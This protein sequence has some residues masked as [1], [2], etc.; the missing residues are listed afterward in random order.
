MNDWMK[1]GE[2]LYFRHFLITGLMVGAVMFLPNNALAQ[3][4]DSNGQQMIQKASEQANAS[5][6]AHITG[7]EKGQ[8][9][10][11]PEQAIKNQGGVNINTPPQ[12]ASKKPTAALQNSVDQAKG[13][14]LSAIRKAEQVVKAPGLEKATTLQ[15]KAVGKNKS[16]P[17]NEAQQSAIHS[18]HRPDSDVE[19]V[20]KAARLVDKFVPQRDMNH[21]PISKKND[22]FEPI[23]PGPVKKGTL[24]SNKEETPNINQVMN[25][26]QRTNSSGGESN[27]RVSHGSNT[28]NGM[29]KWF[30]WNKYHQNQLV[31]PYPSRITL[32]NNQWKNA[33]PSPPPRK[34]PF[35]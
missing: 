2:I 12:A 15:E 16:T 34:A 3:K 33:P 27:D 6:N 19:T 17:K 21:L 29:D 5:V 22:R 30:E 25:P 10:V 14:G 4:N 18:L 31:P 32:F 13:K 35:L 24:P 11:A 8:N 28:I 26:T 7:A 1:G 20:P 9:M 23:V